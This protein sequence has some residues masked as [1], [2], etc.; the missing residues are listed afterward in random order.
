[1]RTKNVFS[2]GL[3]IMAMVILLLASAAS[4][5]DIPKIRSLSVP[6]VGE[7]QIIFHA[8]PG[9]FRVQ[10]RN[11]VDPTAP[12]TDVPEAALTKL[13]SGVY[14]GLIPR[15][16][17]DLGFYQIVS[18]NDGIAELKGWTVVVD[19]STPANGT[20]FI[21]GESPIVTV[22]ILDT[23]AQGLSTVDFSTLSLYMYGPQDPQKTITPVNLL[24]ANPDR[25][26]RPHHYIDLKNNEAVQVN[27]NQLIY[28]LQPVSDEA[29]GTYTI[30]VRAQLAD[31]RMQQIVKLEDLQIGTAEVETQVVAAYAPD[32]SAKCA[33]CHEGTMSGKMYFHHIDPGRSPTGSW[34]LD[35]DPVRSC[36]ICH[37]N[38]GY[39]AYRDRNAPGGRIADPIVRRVH[40]VHNGSHLEKTF[41]I[42]PDSGDFA[43]YI[44]VEFPAD[45]RNCTACHLDDRWKTKPSVF[46]CTGCHDNVWFG[47]KADTPEGMESHAA[48]AIL[49]D[50]A[51]A[52]CHS[53]EGGPLASI[54]DVHQIAP[55][56]FKHTTELTMS[57]P[58]NGEYYVAGETPQVT[59]SIVDLATGEPLDPATLKA[60]ADSSE[61]QADEW[62]RVNFYVSGPR[63]D[64]KP[65]LT[66]AV[67]DMERTYASNDLRVQLDEALEDPNVTR[68][69]DS[70][71][72]QLGDV[73]GLAPGT[74]TAFVEAM[75]AAPLGGWGYINFQVGTADPEPQP[76][77][78]CTD[79]HK[80]TTMHSGYFAVPFTPDICKSCHDNKR[81]IPEMVGW[82]DRNA[83]YGAAPLSR[84]I[85]GVHYGHYVDKPEEIHSRH[86]YSHVIFPQDVRNCTKC[87]DETDSWNKKA[88]RVACLACHD[89]DVTMVH[90]SLMTFDLSPA[91]PW[92]GDEFETCSI[93]HG[94][95]ADFSPAKVHSIANPYVPPYPREHE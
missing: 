17:Q 9:P 46:A 58:A 76:A 30:G 20:H 69:T 10:T 4:A 92:N 65:V 19:I 57:A 62:R 27:Y 25:S 63:T 74:Y 49:D 95:N 91:D 81:Q 56:E 36:K 47:P 86:D 24:N 82:T 72:Y 61:V 71:I 50:S 89:S 43:D 34:S 93:C 88:S 22:S 66:S 79:C 14:M 33:A 5:Q 51:C 6:A 77:S 70:I 75:P 13:S 41:N 31:D 1:M 68:T 80:D 42:D 55:P 78:N 28:A 83:G 67:E 11:S 2:L 39:A 26:A 12:W 29:P 85:H 35:Q 53:P 32:G 18:E 7:M 84:R 90:A 40:G 44:H 37:N 52:Q 59:I 15:G 23:F 45:S 8:G 87:H 3:A 94:E 21:A 38:D 73:A 60:P 16:A 48:G 64:T 54:A